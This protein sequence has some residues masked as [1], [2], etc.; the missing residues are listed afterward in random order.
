MN[1]RIATRK[2]TGA[3]LR[4]QRDQRLSAP[5]P[6]MEASRRADA[7]RAGLTGYA[8]TMDKIAEAYRREDWKALGYESFNAYAGGEFGEARLKLTPD[9][10][11]RILPAFLAVGMSKRGAA[12]AL[13]VDDKTIRNDL[14]GADNSALAGEVAQVKTDAEVAD[15]V[16]R[17]HAS[18]D[19]KYSGDVGS[20]LPDVPG[21]TAADTHNS[22]ADGGQ[23]GSD[24]PTTPPA[25]DGL[26]LNEPV[27]GNPQD[28]SAAL[29]RSS[30]DQS[31]LVAEQPG[32]NS[33]DAPVSEG[34]AGESTANRPGVSSSLAR[35]EVTPPTSGPVGEEPV[36]PQP[37][38]VP[39]A[40]FGVFT[41]GD[42]EGRSAGPDLPS[43]PASELMRAVDG[44]AEALRVLDYD[45][46][47]P[48]LTDTEFKRFDELVLVLPGSVKL[49]RRWASAA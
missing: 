34:P 1:K 18:F 42:E 31:A 41:A 47:G 11:A 38:A 39:S 29:A 7:I 8:A 27:P 33:S 35:D 36:A 25:G 5:G 45:V 9:Q 32:S 3:E 2:P 22:S 48:M 49:L 17:A 14:R 16:A 12:A 46:A 28:A 26:A 4:A 21:K 37:V 43:D 20:S 15:E 30:S 10:R 13:G 6:M 24:L 19:E 23:G 44:L 40:G